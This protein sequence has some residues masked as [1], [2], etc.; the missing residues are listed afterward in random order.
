MDYVGTFDV[1]VSYRTVDARFGAAAA[2]D[3][4]VDRFGV[5]QV[6]LDHASVSPGEP[7]SK[8]IRA[9]LDQARVLVVLIG[10][11]WLS[12]EVDTGTRL[13]DR[14][15]DW[16][17]QE[18]C[19]A[20]EREIAIIPVLLDS[21]Q[22]PLPTDLPDD[23]RDMVKWQ[24]LEV[25]HLSLRADLR[26]L[27]NAV[28][29]YAPV[30]GD[31]EQASRGG[32]ALARPANLESQSP[33]VLAPAEGRFTDSPYRGLLPFDLAHQ[34]VFYGRERL[35]DELVNALAGRLNGHG[36]LMVTGAS[37]VGKSSLV[38][39]GL[40]S[41]M[42]AGR[43]VPGCQ[44]WPQAVMT[45]T[46]H[47][48]DELAVRLAALAG[49]TA[50]SVRDLMLE[51]PGE[52][53]Q[54]IRQ[55]VLTVA[56]KPKAEPGTVTVVPRL[57]LVVDQFEELFTLIPNSRPDAIR[58][59]EAFLA[60]L[61]AA[62]TT[63]VGPT[64][65]P[66]LLVVIVVRSDFWH[67]CLAIPE[68]GELMRDGQFIVGP[69]T[70]PELRRAIIGPAAAAGLHVEPELTDLVLADLRAMG[71]PTGFDVG[72]LPLLSQAMLITWE[73]RTHDRLTIQSYSAT[74]GVFNSITTSA[75]RVYTTL[76]PDEQA[77]TKTVFR[78]LARI[79]SSGQATGRS[80]SRIALYASAPH[81]TPD[82]VDAILNAFA[83]ERLLV[84]NNGNVDIAHDSLLIT[85]QRLHDWLAEDHTDLL[86]HHQLTDDTIRWQ[87][88]NH[89]RAFL[90]R[91]T[92][93]TTAKKAI[94]HWD[95]NPSLHPT[96]TH[97]I[98]R[99]IHLSTQADRRTTTL[100]RTAITTLVLLII[101]TSI[102]AFVAITTAQQN[103]A[104]QLLA[105]SRQLAA[106]ADAITHVNPGLAQRLAAAAWHIAHTPEAHYS[107]LNALAT[108]QRTV[109]TGHAG[110]V[111]SVSFSPNGKIIAT[112]SDD[113]TVRLWDVT[114]RRQIGAPLTGHTNR[115]S[116]VAFSPDGKTLATSSNDHTVRLWNVATHRQINSSLEGHT[117]AVFRVLFSPD[118]RTLASASNDHTVR[119]WDVA[120]HRQIGTPIT[121]DMSSI[122]F[123]PDGKIL[124]IGVNYGTVLL[125]DIATH[126]QISEILTGNV[127]NPISGLAFSPDGKNLATAGQTIVQV[128][129]MSTRRQ[130]GDSFTDGGAALSVVFGPD[131]RTLAIATDYIVRLWDVV[132]HRQVISPL[133]G[134][135]DFV[136]SVAFSPDSKTLA[137]ASNDK[138]VRLWDADTNRQIGDPITDQT[139]FVSNAAFS[140][141][142]KTITTAEPVLVLSQW[143]VTTHRRI[144]DLFTD[145]VNIRTIVA[146][147]SDGKIAALVD[148][149]HSVQLWDVVNHRRIGD[150][151]I[152][153]SDYLFGLA[154]SPNGNILAT[155]SGDQT[156]RLW[157][158]DTS[159]QIGDPITDQTDF[160]YSI[161]F[162]PDGRTLAVAGADYALRLWDVATRRRIGDPSSVTPTASAVRPSVLMA[163]P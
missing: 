107:M 60:A 9:A 84:S 96:P 114:T 71:N 93:L 152:G 87:H 50:S 2:Y 78:H 159:R 161:A 163:R 142:G 33:A 126:H 153:H 128:W 133:A 100:R 67:H 35:T 106:R 75:E 69:M 53:P 92:E 125:W 138:T 104:Q 28:A 118:G 41:A 74:G 108:R 36:L 66:A 45:P 52:T 91:G 13:V 88:A 109:F 11:E 56:E 61:C 129:D 155:A 90:Y 120:T 156:V 19:R 122:R 105:L 29:R 38:R 144:N 111:N 86:I 64:N 139:G 59:R 116:S 22:L 43:L 113:H 101:A 124:A 151:L 46:D 102:T 44:S 160:A 39:A 89:D 134:H 24:A 68:L 72:A 97:H 154:F 141:D 132:T 117:S 55:V 26:R 7:Y 63:D 119:L 79:N 77:I 12:T 148:S 4:L 150:P 34:D 58:Q 62:A 65:Q 135:S 115:V 121:V 82:R 127:N 25:R 1:F 17:R 143:D 81:T 48:V 99:F 85:W 10:P 158:V 123:S 18:I 83:D 162:S 16:V 32:A 8:S 23:I 157:D 20:L 149:D 51:Q 137:S 21:T 30:P 94:A 5:D 42:A 54:L 98:R 112:G 103:R 136:F 40:L 3:S 73:H 27:S 14:P 47:P 76:S 80:A 49:V 145:E 15:G 31:C 146:F 95:T 70:E 147:S 131:S 110:P 37:G 57:L 6:F 140:T 130:I